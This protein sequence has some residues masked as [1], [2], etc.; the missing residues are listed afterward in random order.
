M[1]QD[2]KL[3]EFGR[4]Q[5]PGHRQIP[6][7]QDD[8]SQIREREKEKKNGQGECRGRIRNPPSPTLAAPDTPANDHRCHK[9]HHPVGGGVP[10]A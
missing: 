1:V 6:W 8:T 9:M 10:T 2:I 5:L 4:C 7:W 3:A